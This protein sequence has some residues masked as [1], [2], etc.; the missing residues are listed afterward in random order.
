[1]AYVKKNPKNNGGRPLIN[2]NKEEFEKLCKL[3]CTQ[4]EIA[5]WFD[6]SEE[7]LRRFCKR[8]YGERFCEVYTKLSASGK[9][10]LRRTQ[11]KIA[12]SGNAAMAI[13]LGKQY[14]GQTDK[15]AVEHSGEINN[16][17]SKLTVEE[18]RK[19][20]NENN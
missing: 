8:E 5:G 12:D 15:Q 2:I 17:F 18:L 9:I 13:W 11:F 6:C 3:Q 10:S 4:T 16:P 7:T 20:A 14:L 1:M 19:L